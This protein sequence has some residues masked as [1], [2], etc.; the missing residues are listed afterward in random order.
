MPEPTPSTEPVTA[1]AA[2]D[3]TAEVTDATAEVT[4]ATAEVTDAAPHAPGAGPASPLDL[5][6]DVTTLVAAICDVASVSRDEQALADAIEAALRPLAH[7]EVVRDGNTVVARTHLGRSERVVLAGHIDTVPL[8]AEPNL[9]TRRVGDDLWGRGTVDM[10]GG[11]GVMLRIAAQLAE[12]ERDLTFLFYECEEID[13]RYNGLARVGQTHPELLAGDFAV[14]L[15]PTDGAI[16]GGCKGTLRA[17]VTT[18]GV[19]AHS[20]R[21]WKGH[22]AIHDAATVLSRLT[23]YE[24]ETITVDGLDY[25]EALQAVA[26]SGGIAGNVI[27]DRCTVTVNYRYAPDKDVAEAFAH[28]QHVFE[29]FEVTLGDAADGARPG[30]L[31]PAA[32]AFVEA[33]GVPVNAKEGWTDVARFSTLGVPAVNYGPGDPNLAHMDDEHC[34][35]HQYVDAEA[36]LLRWLG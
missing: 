24:A 22:N 20:A 35:V 4:D 21:P 31:L 16:E 6:A 11:V 8:T 12:P 5:S 9:P 25:H 32:Q 13:A 2:P 30:L 10:K 26:I 7:L 36:A 14:L 19:A 1:D 33:L 34:P 15:E 29:G 3:A 17:D 23:A 28:V 27:P 18:T